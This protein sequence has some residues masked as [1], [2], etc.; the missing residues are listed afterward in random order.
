MNHFSFIFNFLINK[1]SKLLIDKELSEAIKQSLLGF[2]PDNKFS[3]FEID[4][5]KII[6][7]SSTKE[8]NERLPENHKI[9][10]PSKDEKNNKRGILNYLSNSI[11]LE[12]KAMKSPAIIPILFKWDNFTIKKQINHSLILSKIQFIFPMTEFFQAQSKME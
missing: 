1:F 8:R 9:D 12:M 5:Q 11:L 7:I 10:M 6:E 4:P 2:S 3:L